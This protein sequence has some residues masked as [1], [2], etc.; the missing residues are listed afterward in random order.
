MNLIY[1]LR[2]DDRPTLYDRLVTENVANYN[3]IY[4]NKLRMAYE[5][6]DE[7]GLNVHDRPRAIT[8]THPDLSVGS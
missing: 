7:Q 8:D 5:K 3:A 4:R 2:K 6:L 1:D